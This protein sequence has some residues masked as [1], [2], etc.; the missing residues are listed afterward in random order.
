MELTTTHVPRFTKAQALKAT[1]ELK[2]CITIPRHK[3]RECYLG[4]AHRVLGYMDDWEGYLQRECNFEGNVHSTYKAM[5]WAQVEVELFGE[6]PTQSITQSVALELWRLPVEKRRAAYE[7]A[8]TLK[9]VNPLRDV[10]HIVNRLL[11]A[12]DNYGKKKDTP[13]TEENVPVGTVIDVHTGQP[14]T[15]SPKEESRPK[16]SVSSFTPDREE[17]PA[18]EPSVQAEEPEDE[19]ITCWEPGCNNFV[20]NIGNLCLTC[21]TLTSQEDWMNKSR[22]ERM[23]ED[24]GVSVH[25]LPEIE[26]RLKMCRRYLK[27]E[28]SSLSAVVEAVIL[29]YCQIRKDRLAKYEEAE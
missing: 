8:L 29:G 5:Q 19:V 25:I 13:A 11:G 10:K 12:S 9:A 21:S 20:Q 22:E 27:M 23:R 14:V 4:D 2:L 15:D 26:E 16:S 7:D 3:F 1:N 28:T 17:E 24:C 18:E 6:N